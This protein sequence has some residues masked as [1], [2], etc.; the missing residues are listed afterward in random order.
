MRARNAFLGLALVR[1]ASRPR[2]SRAAPVAGDS[3]SRRIARSTLTSAAPPGARCAGS[4]QTGRGCR[5]RRSNLPALFVVR[6]GPPAPVPHGGRA[7]SSSATSRGCGRA[8]QPTVGATFVSAASWDAPLNRSFVRSARRARRKRESAPT[9]RWPTPRAWRRRKSGQARTLAQ[10]RGLPQ[11]NRRRTPPHEENRPSARTLL[12]CQGGDAPATIQPA[13]QQSRRLA[14]KNE[15]TAAA[16][17]V[18]SRSGPDAAPV[19]ATAA[20]AFPPPQPSPAAC[21]R[22]PRHA[23]RAQPGARGPPSGANRAPQG[24][25]SRGRGPLPARR[26]HRQDHRLPAAG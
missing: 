21:Q 25:Y 15:P 2:P 1:L 5:R 12:R 8:P 6:S 10:H 3:Y 23:A 7:A 4:N 20:G 14:R 9:R 18:D 17:G 24:R 22:S 11:K 26:D 19:S 13:T 16:G